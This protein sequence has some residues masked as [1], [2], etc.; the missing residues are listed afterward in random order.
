[1]SDFIDRIRD[2]A[3]I[4]SLASELTVLKGRE[5]RLVGCC[6]FHT[7]QDASFMVFADQGSWHCFGCNRGGSAFDLIMESKGLEF[8]DAVVYLAAKYNIPLPDMTPEE[9]EAQITESKAQETLDAFVQASHD[10]LMRSPETLEYLHLRGITDQSINDYRLGL[11]VKI[12]S[13]TVKQKHALLNAA[14]MLSKAGRP[15]FEDRLIFPVTKHGKVIQLAGRTMCGMEP[16]YL[17]AARDIT[18]WNSHRLKSDRVFITEGIPDAILLEQAGFNAIATVSS[19]FKPEWHRLVG[20]D[21]AC[22][23]CYDG[24]EP[25]QKAN[26]KVSEAL[27]DA[28]HKVWLVTLPAEHDPAS[29][30]QAEGVGAFQALADNA[31]PY[32][33]SLIDKMP[34]ELNDYDVEKEL[35]KIYAKL[36]DQTATSKSR[37]IEKI[38]LKLKMSKAAVKKGLNDYLAATR[39]REGDINPDID[40]WKIKRRT[41]NP[42][43]FN[44]GQD[45]IKD[46]L[47]Y[48]IPF[49]IEGI[50]TF[51]PFVITSEKECFPYNT[52]TLLQR[53]LI[54]KASAVPS[55]Y[56]RWSI[57]TDHKYNAL[58][59]LEGKTH[60]DPKE[61]YN[62]IKWFFKHFVRLP[63]KFYYD[64]LSLWVMATYHYRMYDSFGYIFLN[65]MKR[66]GKTQSL[67]IIA[68]LAFN[69]CM[70]DALTEA[71]LKRRVNV[72]AATIIAD[73][74]EFFKAKL[75][76]EKSM[77]FEVFNGGYKK[78]GR[79]SMVDP[80]TKQVE[81]FCTFSPKALANT[82]GLYDV[83]ADRCITLYLLRSED[84]VPQFVE[85]DYA[86]RF[87]R[88]RDQLYCFSLEHVG[89]LAETKKTLKHPDN[90]PGRDW[91]LWH[92][93]LN[94]AAFLD[95]FDVCDPEEFV[96]S[97]GSRKTITS[98]YERMATMA[99]ERR[100]Y[101]IAQ[102]EDMTNEPKIFRAIWQFINDEF[103]SDE[104]YSTKDICDFIK[105][106]LGWDKYSIQAFSRLIFDTTKLANRKSDKIARDR[107]DSFGKRKKTNM[108][109]LRKEP[110]KEFAKRQFGINLE[111]INESLYSVGDGDPYDED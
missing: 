13:E 88:L 59:Y 78:T 71:V 99:V 37:Y 95:N 56:N 15:M 69:A 47:S 101:R 44:P 111:D 61:L 2:A 11:G 103:I 86:D 57:G 96:L 6:P 63:D 12:K 83:L 90:L 16:K 75:K 84:A 32:I 64:F 9:K 31:A 104:W 38:A 93:I 76:D 23:I 62:H 82:Q 33:D 18:P 51:K 7:E 30:I 107:R 50:G 28:G 54:C 79:A 41:K 94:T 43:F 52:A 105:D 89:G 66:S 53:D 109:R 34:L 91:E 45:I 72:D 110:I 36:S 5:G 68:Q 39:K 17:S 80:D 70:A 24:D 74:A 87:Q 3:D 60:V 48:V 102:E 55:N 4:E 20:K 27:F 14:G 106:D 46:V 40:G 10:K 8:W 73:E 108:I 97:D 25:G 21:T 22:Y 100:E 67:S 81:D 65:A 58:E 19:S 77:V 29:F 35:Q 42:T 26:S 1:M 98:L 49:E 92:P 85:A